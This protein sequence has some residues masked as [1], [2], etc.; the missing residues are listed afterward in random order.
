MTAQDAPLRATVLGSGSWGTTFAAVL[1]D[2]G[3][4]VTVWGRDAATVEEIEELFTTMNWF[5]VFTDRRERS[6]QL[7][8]NTH[9]DDSYMF[10]VM[11]STD[12]IS[13]P[14]GIVR[15]DKFMDQLNELLLGYQHMAS[16]D[17]LPIP[18]AC[19]SYDMNT[20]SEYVARGGS[21]SAAIRASMSIPGV[22]KPMKYNNMV[23]VN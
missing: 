22:F 17:D 10:D 20:G 3:C 21:L 13:M 15:G 23:L 9:K 2:A 5:D 12:D 8:A 1:A 6:Q 19:V 18:F 11:L 14:S 16:F 4:A 7:F